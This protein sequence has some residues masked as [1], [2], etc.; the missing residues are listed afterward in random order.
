[1]WQRGW[2][3]LAWSQLEDPDPPWDLIIV[4]GGITG[5][6]I[7]REAVRAGLKALLV[8][9]RDFASGTSSRSSKLVH[10][11]F[12]YL[13]NLQIRLTYESVREREHLLKQGRGLVSPLGFLMANFV[14][15]RVPAWMLGA[16]LILYDL[17]AFRWGTSHY[18][19]DDLRGLCPPLTSEELIGGYRYIDA[20][21]DDA[22]LVLRVIREAVREGG[23]ALNYARVENLLQQRSGW[24][25]GVLLCDQA[26]ESEGRTIEIRAPV[27]I[28]ATGAWADDLRAHVGGRPRIRKLSGGHLVFPLNKIPLPRAV[29]L[30]HPDDGRPVFGFPWEGVVIFG[31][32]DVDHGEVPQLEPA[33]SQAEVEYLLAA[34]RYAFP[35][36]ALTSD[37][38]Q[39]TWAGVRAVVDTGKVDPSKES[40]EAVLWDEKG[41]LTV[42][43]GKLTTFRLMAHDALRAI[44]RRL[45]GRPSFD[46]RLRMLDKP[47]AESSLYADLAPADRLRLVGRHG[48]DA[49]AILAA[50]GHEE[51]TPIG[52]SPTLWAELRW[53]ARAEG[54]VHLD[55]LLLRRVRLGLL[56]PEGGLP[57]MERIREIV[58]PELG[59][60]NERWDQEVEA[61]RRLWNSCYRFPP[62]E[63]R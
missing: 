42:T 33:I 21:T 7:L 31:T 36:S 37:D 55:D 32:T 17:L 28:N 49:P 6:G 5:A 38:I 63:P 2:R 57:L 10:G 39:S 61:Y 56:L 54:I 45:P 12:R 52:E 3:D 47:P 29:S 15:D 14:N 22:R 35:S 16:G 51:L 44:R 30:F 8:E 18:D 48:A 25:E 23:T 43:G 34:V 4:G 59:W 13:R 41:L 60:H 19:P 46:R 62:S 24:V 27:V 9:A 26:P 50:S 58:L 1:M 53:A 40:R 11:G 20:L